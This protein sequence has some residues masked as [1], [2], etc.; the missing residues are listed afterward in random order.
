MRHDRR[1]DDAQADD[2]M[3]PRLR[4]AAWN[5]PIYRVRGRIEKIFSIGNV[6]TARAE[7][8][9]ESRCRLEAED[10]W[11]Q[12]ANEVAAK[13]IYVHGDSW[14]LGTNIPGKPRVCMAYAGGLGPYRKHYDEVAATGYKG[15]RIPAAS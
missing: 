5:Q 12:H 2:T 4:V 3:D 7:C 11:V 9:G 1:I 10:A 14:C 13:M 8:D 6:A 15:L